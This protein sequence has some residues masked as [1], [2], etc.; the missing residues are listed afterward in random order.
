MSQ[1]NTEQ[2]K[3]AWTSLIHAPLLDIVKFLIVIGA[4]TW[5]MARGTEKL[6]YIWHWHRIPHYIFLMRIALS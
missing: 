4:I 3:G 1:Q 5:L 2:Q 6:G